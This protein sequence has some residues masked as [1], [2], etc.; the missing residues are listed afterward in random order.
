MSVKVFV[1][2]PFLI[3]LSHEVRDPGV[4]GGGVKG[5]GEG[6]AIRRD[7]Y[8]EILHLRWELVLES[9]AQLAL[10]EFFKELGFLFHQDEFA[11]I[12]D[13]DPIGHLLRFLDVVRGEDHGH[14]TFPELFYH[15]PH[16]PA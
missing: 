9:H 8:R 1:V 16:L 11:L 2:D 5:I 13:A 10:S 6:Q 14:P 12:D 3:E 4:G 15:L 7:L